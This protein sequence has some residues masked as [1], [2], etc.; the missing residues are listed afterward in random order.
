[1]LYI[2]QARKY[3]RSSSLLSHSNLESSAA[4]RAEAETKQVLVHLVLTNVLVIALDVA[5]LGVQYAGLFY[6]QG[7]FKPCV[8]GVKLKVEFA[9]LNRLVETVRIRGQRAAGSY[10]DPARS[11]GSGGGGGGLFGPVAGGRHPAATTAAVAATPGKAGRVQPQIL[12]SGYAG[13]SKWEEEDETPDASS[14]RVEQIG[15]GTLDHRPARGASR[16]HS[17]ESQ[18]PIWDGQ[19]PG[20][21]NAAVVNPSNAEHQPQWRQVYH[22]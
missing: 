17:Q 4:A 7:A 15:L 3:L 10:Y 6:L 21:G 19:E 8:Y 13:E 18:Q 16:S 9:I 14:R 1:M 20:R 2:W 11:G 5:L 22:R 12:V